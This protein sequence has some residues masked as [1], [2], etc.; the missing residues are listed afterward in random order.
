ME[1]QSTR[2]VKR[3]S[4]RA[5]FRFALAVLAIG[6]CPAVAQNPTRAP[7]AQTLAEK[8]EKE[9]PW[10]VVP[11]FSVSPKLGTSLGVLAGYL[12][13]FD[14]L[15]RVSMFGVTAQYTSTGS[16]VGGAFGKASFGEDHHRLIAAVVGGNIKNDYSDY[17]GTGVPLQSN[18]ELHAVVSRYLYRLKDDWF[19][20][21]QGLYTNYAVVGQTAFDEQVLDIL[22]IQGFKSGGIGA[23][24][25]H[26]SR[27][28]ENNP[29]RGWL[30]NANNIAY[31]EWIGG[32]QDFDVYRMDFR[33]FW[34]HGNGNVFAVRQNN[35]WTVDAPPAAFAPVQLRG[36]KMGQYLGKNMSSLEGEERLSIG[37]RWTAT[38]FTGVACLYGNGRGCSDSANLY[39]DYGA[40][41]QYILKRREGIV[42]NLEY[43][44]GKGGNYG[45]Y[46]KLG[47]GF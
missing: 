7:A 26:D 38:L 3:Q 45:V 39:P 5:S 15:S 8:A 19:I 28:N 47:Y 22:G 21:V 13:Y 12:H 46:L 35:Q 11:L 32:S 14:E 10:L 33:S 43:A 31:R 42:A 29:T 9:S 30:L 37:E 17:L 36:Y 1:T 18:D 40:G 2:S 20:G 4:V 41:I 27:D 24:A 44:A 34:A 25:Y 16:M 23:A 6:A